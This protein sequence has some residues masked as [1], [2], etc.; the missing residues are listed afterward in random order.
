LNSIGVGKIKDAFKF[1]S[2]DLAFPRTNL[3]AK[4][5]PSF[6]AADWR[7]EFVRGGYAATHKFILGLSNARILIARAALF[8]FIRSHN[9]PIG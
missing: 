1:K 9:F 6:G 4:P 8:C 2:L 3:S 5:V 7:D